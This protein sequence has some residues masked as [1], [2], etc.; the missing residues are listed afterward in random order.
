MKR[1]RKRL[2]LLLAA[3]LITASL[4]QTVT[5]LADVNPAEKNVSV[6]KTDEAGKT[7]TETDKVQS[8]GKRQMTED[9]VTESEEAEGTEKTETEGD[10]TET[11]SDAY[12]PMPMSLRPLTK[13]EVTLN[14]LSYSEADLES[15]TVE[16]I[17]SLL[18]DENGEPVDVPQDKKVVW[19]YFEDENGNTL[20]DELHEI[21][22][23]ETV[24]WPDANEHSNKSFKMELIIGND[25]HLA[26]LFE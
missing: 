22:R 21:G 23:G 6:E 16:T 11:D 18:R 20:H 24:N 10:A 17:L 13:K 1:F 2:S 3:I 7:V 12:K 5:V 25:V 19:A 26:H 15:M 14:L 8:D 9:E 4:G